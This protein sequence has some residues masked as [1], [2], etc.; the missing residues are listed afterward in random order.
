MRKMI[1][2]LVTACFIAQISV[3]A[4]GG[5]YFVSANTS[6]GNR[7]VSLGYK[8][9]FGPADE[10]KKETTLIDK[11]KQEDTGGAGTA[12][13]LIVLGGCLVAAAII[14]ANKA[15]D[16]ADRAEDKTDEIQESVDEKYEEAKEELEEHEGDIDEL[17]DEIEENRD[18]S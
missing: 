2:M 11:Y 1:V 18:Q 4:Y 3:S 14:L 10:A 7:E 5:S 8:F 17:R 9:K 12:I 15:D 13:A 6:G 16:I